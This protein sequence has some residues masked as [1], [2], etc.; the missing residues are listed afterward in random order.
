MDRNGGGSALYVSSEV[1]CRVISINDTVED[2]LF[3]EIRPTSTTCALVGV[4]YRPPLSDLL[5]VCNNI[6]R[7][8]N[9]RYTNVLLMGD[10][11]CPRATLATASSDS[12]DAH[13]LVQ[14]MSDLHLTQ[15][16]TEA[17][18]YGSDGRGSLLDLIFTNEEHM[19]SSMQMSPSKSMVTMH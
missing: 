15:H 8:I 13:P 11:N 17:T 18:R 6:R 14:L 19:I 9:R 16:V 12:S 1:P 10:F 2:S 7:V 4:I 5:E 3:C